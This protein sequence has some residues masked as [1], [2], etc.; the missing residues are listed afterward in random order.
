MIAPRFRLPVRL[1]A[2]G[3][4]LA[5]IDGPVPAGQPGDGLEAPAGGA[6]GRLETP[7]GGAGD[8][9]GTPVVHVAEVDA[10]IHPASA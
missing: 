7:A 10:P 5:A 8:R 1:I 4:I 6:G 3:A 2:I 9:P